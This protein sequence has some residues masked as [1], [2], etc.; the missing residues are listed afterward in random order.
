[1][2]KVMNL[3]KV[4]I[5]GFFIFCQ[6]ATG[7][8]NPYKID[9]QLYTYYQLCNRSIKDSHVIL[10]ADTL[11]QMALQKKDIKAQCLAKNLKAEHYYYT[12]NIDS[13]LIEKEKVADFARKTPFKQY[14]FGAWNR[15][16]T[17]YLR[18]R[19]HEAAIKEIKKYQDEAILLNIPYGIGKSYIRMG[20]A[21]YQQNE[22]QAA[23]EQ[24]M[25]A[26]EYYQSI[27]QE[28]EIDYAYYKVGNCYIDLNQLEQA[29]K[30]ILK[31]IETSLLESSKASYYLGLMRIY[32]RTENLEKAKET[33]KI[34][35]QYKNKG[36][37]KG[38]GLENYYIIIGTYYI[39]CKDYD[40]ALVYCDSVKDPQLKTNLKRLVYAES[41]D[42]K[43]AY[44]YLKH[45]MSIQDSLYKSNNAKLL[46]TQN[47]RFNNQRLELERNKLLLQNTQMKLKQSQDREQLI[48]LET[49]QTRIELENRSLQLD[50]QRT[51]TE[52]EKAKT[53]KQHLELMHKQ[54][55]LRR[56]EIEKTASKRMGIVLIAI[57]TLIT[58]FSIMYALTRQKHAKRLQIEKDAAEAARKQAEKADKLKS[59]F[60][61]NMSHEIRTPLNAI[62]GFNDILNDSS[63]ELSQEERQELLSHLHTN[64]ALLLTLVNDILDLSKLESG[65]YN[66]SLCKVTLPEL[67]QSAIAGVSHRVHEGVQLLLQQPPTEIIITTDGQRLQQILNNLLVNACK[68]T[69]QGSIT[70]AYEQKDGKIRFSV[71]DTGCGIPKDKAEI[72]FQRFEKLDSFQVGFGL[73]LSICRSLTK[74][75]GGEIYL[76]INYTGGA[77]FIVEFPL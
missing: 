35:S 61:Q 13:L 43:T 64:T 3:A 32:T 50:Q 28:N 15:I 58:G 14:I 59:A 68:Y 53:Q 26:I 30:Y 55:E 9:N 10:M 1:M 70:L 18:Y 46:A 37:F 20:D 38:G 54:E 76:D 36:I 72:I 25:Q 7:Q 5:I 27:K 11:F 63:M 2:G 21:Y 56:I 12:D 71:T 41:G 77:R 47:A 49:E 65:N 31:A 16:I 62:V 69:Q 60:L 24:Y 51:A 4:I 34:L 52:L 45:T 33:K 48:S 66:I 8:N 42:F 67:C 17:Y 74:A 23:L 40:H 22:G 73:G 39:K 6:T 29:E 75:L 57:L 44:D 19:E